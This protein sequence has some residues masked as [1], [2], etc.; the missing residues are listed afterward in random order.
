MALSVGEVFA[1][2]AFERIGGAAAGKFVDFLVETRGWKFV[3]DG[4][5]KVVKIL[6]KE[7]AEVEK[8]LMMRELTLAEKEY[9]KQFVL[10]VYKEVRGT[11]GVSAA[12]HG[13]MS[14]WMKA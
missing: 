6:S 11:K 10:G 9:A 5:G 8:A 2:A 3:T 12:H 13:V 4:A 1:K 7:G 14:Q